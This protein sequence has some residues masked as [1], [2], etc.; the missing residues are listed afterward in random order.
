MNSVCCWRCRFEFLSLSLVRYFVFL[1]ANLL[2]FSSQ[3]TYIFFSYLVVVVIVLLCVVCFHR[4][5][6][7]FRPPHKFHFFFLPIFCMN[8]VEWNKEISILRVR[9]ME[10][11]CFDMYVSGKCEMEFVVV[12]FESDSDNANGRTKDVFAVNEKEIPKNKAN[13]KLKC[14]HTQKK[15]CG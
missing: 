14:I 13:T 10:K 1:L 11:A 12:T 8:Y 6:N 2:A 7:P 9:D 15:K 5:H 4:V 3:F